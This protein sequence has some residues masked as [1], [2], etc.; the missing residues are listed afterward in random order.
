M[1]SDLQ[2]AILNVLTDAEEGL[3]ALQIAREVIGP[4]ATRK[5][6]NPSLYKMEKSKL[7]T[8]TILEGTS[9][10]MWTVT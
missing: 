1:A 2:H 5:L 9:R 7:L 4:K 8:R 6:V 3:D 10:P